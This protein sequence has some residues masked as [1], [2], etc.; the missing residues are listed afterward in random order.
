M[1]FTDG[2]VRLYDRTPS[3][4]SLWPWGGGGPMGGAVDDG[5]GSLI[6]SGTNAPLFRTSFAP[7]RPRQKM[8]RST[9]SA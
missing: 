8:R 4:E 2:D 6:Q 7:Q 1:G 3:G 9:R 5:H